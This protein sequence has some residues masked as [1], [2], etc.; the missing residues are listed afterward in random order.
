MADGF[1]AHRQQDAVAEKLAV[2]ELDVRAAGGLRSAGLDAAVQVL[3]PYKP[4]ADP[5]AARSFAGQEPA[6]AAGEPERPD[7][8]LAQPAPMAHSQSG[9][10]S[11]V[12]SLQA[13]LQP[14]E[15]PAH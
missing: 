6:G 8:Q 3:V 7:E 2:R 4:D 12:R 10:D 9:L 1:L 11:P 15:L 13:E 14:A 5:S